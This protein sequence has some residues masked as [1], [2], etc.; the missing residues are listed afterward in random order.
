MSE[1]IEK[2][3]ICAK[4]PQNMRQNI[5][6]LHVFDD[7]SIN[8]KNVLFVT[9]DDRVYGLGDNSFGCLGLGHLSTVQSPQIIP[10]LCGHMVQ[11]FMNSGYNSVNNIHVI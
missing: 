10:E 2:F 9:L 3:R 4:I 11:G 1:I 8:N 6:L 7:Y 5:K